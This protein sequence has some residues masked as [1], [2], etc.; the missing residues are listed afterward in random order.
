MINVGQVRAHIEATE[1]DVLAVP[2]LQLVE[3]LAEV[4]LGQHARRA[5]INVR[6]LVNIGANASGAGA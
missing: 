5:L 3:M 4:E 1:G 6:T 2:K